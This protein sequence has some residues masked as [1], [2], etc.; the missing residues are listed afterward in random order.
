MATKKNYKNLEKKLSLKN[1]SAWEI[2]DEKIK[3]E[4]FSFAE[5]YKTFLNNGK[6]VQEV[7][8]ETILFAEKKGY[9]EISGTKRLKMG[10]KVYSAKNG[11]NIILAQIGK[12]GF[13]AGISI[14][15]AHIDS[16]HLDLKSRPLY[17]DDGLALMKTHY[18]GGIKK[19]QWPTVNLAIHGKIC[20]DNGKNIDIKIGEKEDD[21]VFMITDLLPHLDKDKE[22][23]I[24]ILG[25]QLN[26]VVGG[27]PVKD[28]AVKE[29]VKLSVLEYLHDNYGIKEDDLTS[30]DL[31]IV[32]GGRARDLGFDRSMISGYGHD[33]KSSA[34]CSL[35]ALL[36]LKPVNK[37]QI[38]ILVGREEIGSDGTGSAKSVFIE[39][40]I[41]N[42]LKLLGKNNGM[43]EVYNIFSKSRAISTETTAALDPD[44][45]D[46][47]DLRN[48][49]ILSHGVIIEKY[50]GGG[51]KYS[52]SEATADYL[53]DL[54][55]LFNK[56]KNIVYNISGGMG[57]V[58]VG[59]GGTVS[60]YLANRN[61][62]TVDMAIPTLNLHAPLEIISKADLYSAYLAYKEFL[63]N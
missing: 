22:K 55:V 25:E 29:K 19:Y 44:Y 59:G 28:E 37:T 46:V 52:S 15:I 16:P 10:D 53:R 33:D 48:S 2:W 30:A 45:K 50:T 38:C 60:K 27:I 23:E 51:G 57:K 9:K 17:E 1:I 63:N 11:D 56:N 61:I 20:L 39:S 62:D 3:K 21:P 36:D 58:D 35:K 40:F 31:A 14:L 43:E 18:Y 12:K 8:K 47:M 41:S 24:K 26:L 54:R 42:L 5:D 32:P 13:E 34:Y 4:S 49:H 6:T 7:V